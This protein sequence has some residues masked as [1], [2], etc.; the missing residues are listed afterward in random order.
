MPTYTYNNR[1]GILFILQ[2]TNITKRIT[3]ALIECSHHLK[4]PWD[5]FFVLIYEYW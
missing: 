1:I 2:V 3:W 4:N 5:A